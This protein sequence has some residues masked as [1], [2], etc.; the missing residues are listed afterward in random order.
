MKKTRSIDPRSSRDS[1]NRNPE[2]QIRVL[3]HCFRPSLSP[4]GAAEY[5]PGSAEPKRGDPGCIASRPGSKP[6]TPPHKAYTSGVCNQPRHTLAPRSRN[7]P[8]PSHLLRHHSVAPSA[9]ASPQSNT[10][11]CPSAK[12][13]AHPTLP[14]S[15]WSRWHHPRSRL[16]PAPQIVVWRR[17]PRNLTA[18]SCSTAG[19]R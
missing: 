17:A 6:I 15:R 2:L 19:R 7:T 13:S 5:S 4:E 10:Q 1:P 8:I 11:T 14:G 3:I 18:G 9:T 12:I 16:L